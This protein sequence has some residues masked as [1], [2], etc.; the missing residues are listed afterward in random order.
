M[1]KK[2]ISKLMTIVAKIE[3]AEKEE[4]PP[5]ALERLTEAKL[6]VCAAVHGA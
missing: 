2:Q 3:A 1:T 5:L 6:A 4:L